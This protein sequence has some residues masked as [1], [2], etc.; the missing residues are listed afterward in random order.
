MLVSAARHASGMEVWMNT[1]LQRLLADESGST[2]IQY[3]L[4][5]TLVS[6]GIIAGLTAFAGSA[7]DLWNGIATT[8]LGAL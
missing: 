1:Q 3:A 4:I 5:A 6:I 7:S 8:I 2:A